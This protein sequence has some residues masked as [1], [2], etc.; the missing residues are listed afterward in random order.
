MTFSGSSIIDHCSGK[1]PRQTNITR[2]VKLCILIYCARKTARIKRSAHKEINFC[3]LKNHTADGYQK[4]FCEFKFSNYEDF[5]NVND[6]YRNS[7]Q[8]LAPVNRIITSSQEW[9]VVRFQKS[10]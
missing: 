1:F 2:N 5:D 6:T 10:V 9:S 8:T 7:I 4:A 3:Y